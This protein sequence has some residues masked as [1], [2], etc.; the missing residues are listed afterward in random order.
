MAARLR[1]GKARARRYA[2]D[3]AFLACDGISRA[4]LFNAVGLG[5]LLTRMRL[6][7]GRPR[8]VWG[9][10]PILTLPL[11]ARC[12]RLLGISAESVVLHQY[13]VTGAFDVNLARLAKWIASVDFRLYQAF[14]RVLLA[15]ALLRYDFF[16]YFADR[17]FLPPEHDFGG[18]HPAELRALKAAGKRLYV[19]TYGADVRTRERTLQNGRWNMCA[20]CPSPGTYCICDMQ[21]AAEVFAGIGQTANAIVT[22]GDMSQYVP[23]SRRLDYWPVDTDKLTFQPAPKDTVLRV[24]HAPNHPFF[25]GTQFLVDAIERL[26]AEGEDIEL[27][28]VQGV[29]NA[30]VLRLFASAAVIADQFIAGSFGY[31]MLEGMALG[32]PVLCFIRESQMPTAAEECPVINVTPDTLYETLRWCLRNR[33]RLAELGTAARRYIERHHSLPAVALRLGDLYRRTADLPERAR[34]RIAARSEALARQLP[35][36]CPIALPVTVKA[37]ALPT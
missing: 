1:R 19:F 11:K 3:A 2:A 8:A 29:P 15:V 23:G 7:L 17:G 31:T 13:Y 4:L 10:T 6:A 34:A 5:A 26:R 35:A 22:M 12:D 9:I 20:A 30:Q 18:I 32:R 27:V 28:K 21:R 14:C 24:A 37:E 33:D 36:A 16:H 25:K